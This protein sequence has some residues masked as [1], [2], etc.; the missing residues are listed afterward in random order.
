VLKFHDSV[1]AAGPKCQRAEALWINGKRFS[2]A[3]A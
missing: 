2:P 3:Q 1:R